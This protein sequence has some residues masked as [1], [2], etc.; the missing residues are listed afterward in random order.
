MTEA[1]RQ[2]EAAGV[3]GLGC[4]YAV[5]FT[6]FFDGAEPP[7]CASAILVL[8]DSAASFAAL[9]PSESRVGV[10][11]FDDS[12]GGTGECEIPEMLLMRFPFAERGPGPL[13][14]FP[15]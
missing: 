7:F 10:G 5:L 6:T 2:G 12:V 9:S 4:D 11:A 1:S 15:S 3:G 8:D 13:L 14:K